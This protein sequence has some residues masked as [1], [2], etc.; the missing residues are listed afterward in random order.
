MR[1]ELG[2][3]SGSKKLGLLNPAFPLDAA[4]E[5][6]QRLNAADIRCRPLRDLNECSHAFAM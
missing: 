1:R 2:F 6:Q 4:V 3:I 5:L